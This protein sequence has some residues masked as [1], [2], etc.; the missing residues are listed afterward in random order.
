MQWIPHTSKHIKRLLVQVSIPFIAKDIA[1]IKLL[2][3]GG[4]HLEFSHEKVDEKNGK[5][6]QILNISEKKPQLFKIVNRKS[7]RTCICYKTPYTTGVPW[8]KNVPFEIS[9][10]VVSSFWESQMVKTALV[11]VSKL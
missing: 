3:T 9:K 7:H 6:F 10:E 8:S 11:S 4:N 5:F 1:I 2:V